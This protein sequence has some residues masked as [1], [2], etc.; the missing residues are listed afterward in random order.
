MRRRDFLA[1]SGWLFAGGVVTACGGPRPGPIINTKSGQIQGQEIAGIHQYLGIPYAEP[2]FGEL[3][4][5]PPQRRAPW[6]GVLSAQQYGAACPQGRVSAT[7]P[8]VIG[9]DCLNLNIWTP[10]PSASDLPVMVWAHG[11]EGD[12]G[13]GALAI[14]NG[15][16][17]AAQGV[18]LVTC[19]RR[20]GA[21]SSLYLQPSMGADV[22]PGN[23]GVLDLAEVLRW[24]QE[25]INAFGGNPGNVTLFGHTRGAAAAQALV[26]TTNSAGLL[27]RIIPQNGAYAA[28]SEEQ[29][30]QV[31]DFVLSELGIKRGDIDALRRCSSTQLTKLY[32]QLLKLGLGDPYQP[33]I[34][35]AMP[36]HPADAAHAGFGLALDYLTGSC[37]DVGT[38]RQRSAMREHQFALAQRVLALD[39]VERQT[40]LQVYRRQYPELGELQAE[41][42]ILNDLSYRL[43]TLRVAHGHAL[44]GTGSTYC[45]SF[46]A[47]VL[48]QRSVLEGD[49]AVFGNGYPAVQSETADAISASAS[50]SQFMRSA[51]C[52]F[53]RSGSPSVANFSWPEYDTRLQM[54]AIIDDVP[55]MQSGPF[56][57]QRRVLGRVMTD[58]WQALGL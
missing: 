19:N 57:Q 27:Q 7:D 52:N 40:L 55:Q 3:R 21:E 17:F 16:N 48:Q 35:E 25:H 33:V 54:T 45:Y 56:S 34:C 36:V 38:D 10:D 6:Q 9:E 53:A 1:A 39:S 44:R 22:G 4:F 41:R 24:V 23:L 29:G 30:Q 37:V 31:S 13:S 14:Y 42:A 12:T 2:P 11:G 47:A 28:H 8:L 18:V 51:W 32:P 49:L 50:V 46:E 15:A 20:L 5:R 26:A 43:P 58:S